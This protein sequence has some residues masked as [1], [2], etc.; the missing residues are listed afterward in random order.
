MEERERSEQLLELGLLLI[1]TGLMVALVTAGAL[2]M[3]AKA[4]IIESSVQ[5]QA[6]SAA[7]ILGVLTLVLALLRKVMRIMGTR[8]P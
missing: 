8:S 5:W 7:F 1:L 3:V 4:S 6:V 2:A